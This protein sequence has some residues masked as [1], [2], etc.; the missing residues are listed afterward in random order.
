MESL[1]PR[2]CVSSKEAQL[3]M[4]I[5]E[6]NVDGA[7]AVTITPTLYVNN[8][9]A[10]IASPLCEEDWKGNVVPALPLVRG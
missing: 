3:A 4:W 2:S 6:V 7:D 8:G 1:R 9:L 10:A 5:I